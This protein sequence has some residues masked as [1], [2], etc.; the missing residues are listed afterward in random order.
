MIS[1]LPDPEIVLREF[2]EEMHGWEIESR[3]RS[4]RIQRGEL[5]PEQSHQDSRDALRAI[6]ERFRA[7]GDY[8]ER[9]IQ[10][11]HPPE[12]DPHTEKITELRHV[13]SDRIEL[14]TQ[15]TEGWR[16]RRKF[17]LCVI[18]GKWR[19]ASKHRVNAGGDEVEESL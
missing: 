3:A 16:H 1:D 19:I 9:G 13:A 14:F 12:Y 17:T 2:F 4:K 5:E 18:E 15:Q 11:Q 8:S 7:P 10:Y 6:L